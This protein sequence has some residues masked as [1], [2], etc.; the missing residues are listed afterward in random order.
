MDRS[1]VIN[2]VFRKLEAKKVLFITTKNLDYL[3]NTQEINLLNEVGAEYTVI[4][5][6]DKSYVRRLIKVFTEILKT[7]ISCYDAVFIGF[8]PQFII[9]FFKWKFRNKYV[10]IDFF[11][12]FYD[13]LVFDRKK[14]KEKSFVAKI[15]KYLDAKTIKAA[16]EIIVDTRAHGKYF[17]DEFDADMRRINVLYLEADEKIYY[18]KNVIKEKIFQDRFLVVYFGSVLPLQGVDVVLDAIRLL[19]NDQ[20]IHF[21]FIGPLTD[22]YDKI[23]ADNVTYYSWLE[24]ETLADYIAQADLCLAGHFN[25]HINKAKRTIPG[26]AYIYKAMD[27]KVIFG[28]NDANRELH[29]ENDQSNYFVPMG[30]AIALAKLIKDIASSEKKG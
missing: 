15:L 28:E 2:Q 7:K 25:K 10:I 26:K 27:K 30:D 1:K 18:P 17:V 24:Q 11:I 8:A 21:L 12:S 13:T 23:E 22:N 19:K 4:G 16:N 5:S 9:P 20:E 14:F 3:R 29:D 6:Y